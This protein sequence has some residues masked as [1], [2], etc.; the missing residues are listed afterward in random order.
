MN[1][2]PIVHLLTLTPNQLEIL[3]YLARKH[4]R[5]IYEDTN[6]CKTSL[7]GLLHKLDHCEEVQRKRAER[8]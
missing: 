4:A 6:Y 2:T 5:S 8:R 3:L 1:R 7:K